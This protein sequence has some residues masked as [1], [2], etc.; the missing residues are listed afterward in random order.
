VGDDLCSA[1]DPTGNCI[2]SGTASVYRDDDP[3]A[4]SPDGLH[5]VFALVEDNQ[6]LRLYHHD[7]QTD[8]RRYSVLLDVPSNYFT[9][10]CYNRQPWQYKAV[11][12]PIRFTPDG[13]EV[14]FLGWDDCGD[15]KDK[16]WT[17]IVGVKRD[18]IGGGKKV[19]E[20]DLRKVTDNP[21]GKVTKNIAVSW[22]DLSPSGQYTTFL[23]TPTLLE[24]GTG[25]VP[26]ISDRQ[27]NDSEVYVTATDGSTTPVQLTNEVNWSTTSVIA[28][29]TPK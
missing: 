8:L 15:S 16:P 29:P 12:S 1:R 4:L 26:D 9:N 27:V 24:D 5:L 28:V 3:I 7:L 10:A 22:F 25:W 21:V 11:R 20:A 13:S 6:Q 19:T 14:L 18:F 23:G 2:G 17:N